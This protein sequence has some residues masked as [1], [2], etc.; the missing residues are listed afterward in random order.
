MP[1]S[2]LRQGALSLVTPSQ[3]CSAPASTHAKLSQ[4]ATPSAK[5][6]G[7]PQLTNST[8]FP[9]S[10]WGHMEPDGQQTGCSRSQAACQAAEGFSG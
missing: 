9:S 6:D 1:L 8:P 10:Q 4:E 5:E 2:Q 7:T 3:G